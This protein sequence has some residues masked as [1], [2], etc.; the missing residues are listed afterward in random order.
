M[1]AQYH[2]RAA[3]GVEYFGDLVGGETFGKSS[4]PGSSLLKEAMSDAS[5][6][7]ISDAFLYLVI[8]HAIGDNHLYQY[9]A[10]FLDEESWQARRMALKNLLRDK[11]AQIICL[12]TA[13]RASYQRLCE[14]L[15]ADNQKEPI[16]N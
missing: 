12:R 3:L 5:K 7:E 10:G 16:Q 14:E 9:Q 2:N 4:N 6:E 8:Y 1:A 11:S 13:F 15:I